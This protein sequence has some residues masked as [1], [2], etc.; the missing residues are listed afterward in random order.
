MAN[1]NVK[2]RLNR[3]SNEVTK[4]LTQVRDYSGMDLTEAIMID[5][6]CCSIIEQLTKISIISREKMGEKHATKL[7]KRVR[8]ALGYVIP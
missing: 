4:T 6:T 1:I 7:T 8:K 3:I 5:N 2:I